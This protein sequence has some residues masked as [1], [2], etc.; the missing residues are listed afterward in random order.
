MAFAPA[1][2]E[3]GT[4][5]DARAIRS[6]PTLANGVSPGDGSGSGNCE[7]ELPGAT[8]QGCRIS[9]RVEARFANGEGTPCRGA[10][11]PLRKIVRYGWAEVEKPGSS[12]RRSMGSCRRA[13][14]HRVPQGESCSPFQGSSP[15]LS[16]ASV[17][18]QNVASWR[19]WNKPK[20]PMASKPSSRGD[21][22]ATVR[23][24]LR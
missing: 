6:E 21:R 14:H 15:S 2:P 22:R 1:P 11:R 12:R 8:S 5:A 20:C 16:H 19:A 9:V 7:L 18:R 3:T 23:R 24:A 4:G 17:L 10:Q 13:L